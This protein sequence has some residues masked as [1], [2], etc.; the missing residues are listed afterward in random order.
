[1][2]KFEEEK[3]RFD[4]VIQGY[5]ESLAESGEEKNNYN[6]K[7][8]DKER[9][10]AESKELAAKAE[11]SNPMVILK[12]RLNRIIETN[13]EKRK[14]MDQYLKNVKVIEDSFD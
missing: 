3:N 9:E 2:A 6:Q 11:H 1:M 4:V 10:E 7:K 8:K 14:L 12:R 5:N 13:K